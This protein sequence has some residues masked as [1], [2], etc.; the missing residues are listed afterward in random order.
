MTSPCSR[1]VPIEQNPPYRTT[2]T[3]A[4]HR[5]NAAAEALPPPPPPHRH[6]RINELGK[7]DRAPHAA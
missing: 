6:Q 2:S 5:S 4:T 7:W 3:A 1:R